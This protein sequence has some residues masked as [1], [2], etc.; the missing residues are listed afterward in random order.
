MAQN[1]TSKEWAKHL[2]EVYL[3]VSVELMLII[4]HVKQLVMKSV[5]YRP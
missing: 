4:I 2:I 3:E 5:R 1:L